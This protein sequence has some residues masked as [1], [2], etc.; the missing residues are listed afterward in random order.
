MRSHGT[1]ASRPR[2]SP[3]N[4]SQFQSFSQCPM[5]ALPGDRIGSAKTGHYLRPTPKLAFRVGAGRVRP[6]CPVPSSWHSPG[7]AP[8]SQG[9]T[10]GIQASVSEETP[11]GGLPSRDH[12]ANH[13]TDTSARRAV[14][15]DWALQPS[16]ARPVLHRL[17][18]L[19]WERR[20]RLVRRPSSQSAPRCP[21]Q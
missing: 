8:R 16:G 2:R 6:W 1:A 13:W 17:R 7:R 9:A 21:T 18:R 20:H 14:R 3:G 4:P 15:L 10:S 19:R 11:R 12:V 5:S